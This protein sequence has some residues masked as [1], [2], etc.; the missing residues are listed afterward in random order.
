MRSR[1]PALRSGRPHKPPSV[2]HG[3]EAQPR[4]AAC[5]LPGEGRAADEARLVTEWREESRGA[6]LA[7]Q[8]SVKSPSGS[9]GPGAASSVEPLVIVYASRE[10][11][12]IGRVL[13]SSSAV[14]PLKSIAPKS[15]SPSW[16]LAFFS[17][18][19]LTL[20]YPSAVDGLGVLSDQ[21]HP[22]VVSA[23]ESVQVPPEMLTA[24]A[25]ASPGETG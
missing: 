2:G 11:A 8:V 22:F 10:K 21:V 20:S 24:A 3:R 16:L 25:I 15:A 4:P 13:P 1:R 14:A 7:Y 9:I 5:L 17:T 18:K 12:V 6:Q 19:T 23:I